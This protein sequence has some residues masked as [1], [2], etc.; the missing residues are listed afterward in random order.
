MSVWAVLAAAGSGE[1]LGADRPKAFAR[2]GGRP[3]LAESLERLDGSDWIDAIV[4]AAPPEWEEP[5]I[6]LAEELGCGKVAPASPA[7]R[8]AR[9]RCGSASR[10]CPRTRRWCSSTT[11][12]GR[13]LPEDVIERV[14]APLGEGWDGAVPGAAARGHGQARRGRPRGRDA[15]A[16]TSSSPCRRRRPSSPTSCAQAL[17]GDARRRDRL[18]LARRGARRPGEGRRGRSAAAQGDDAGRP[19]ARRELARPRNRRGVIVD[20]HMHLRDRPGGEA[21]AATARAR[22]AR[23]SSTAR[24]RGVDEIGFTEH[25][26]YFR[27]TPSALGAAVPMRERCVYDLDDVRRRGRR[28]EAAR[29]AGQARARGRLRRRASRHELARAARAVPVGLPARLGALSSTGSPSTRSPGS[30]QK[31]PVDEA[32]APLLRALRERA[33]AAGSSTCS[34]TRTW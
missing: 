1:R 19:R 21:R 8:R 22:R 25:V 27:Q 34:R 12:R 4:V 7:A 6:L 29:A 14:L 23:S 18:R 5:A 31:L 3:L 13:S 2:L 20:Y 24:A 15:R 33:R 26:Y 28:G 11:R 16:R 17:A 9:S 32:L 10:R 30:G